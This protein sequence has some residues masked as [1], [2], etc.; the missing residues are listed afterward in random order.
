[1]L[2]ATSAPGYVLDR[3]ALLAF[4]AATPSKARLVVVDL[5]V[6]RDVEPIDDPSLEVIDME[7][8][9]CAA[10]TNRALRASA[11]AKAEVLVERKLEAFVKRSTQAALA[12]T[13]AEVRCESESVFERELSQLFVGKLAGLGQDERRAIEHWA[14]TAFGRVNHVPINAIKRLA[15]DRALFGTH[16]GAEGNA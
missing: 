14:R 6:P 8:L 16:P 12:E 5:A 4:A 7:A 9:R 15:N 10:E 1:M 3:R 11:A 13:L 2:S